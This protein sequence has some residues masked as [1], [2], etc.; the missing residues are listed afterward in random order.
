[1]LH[2]GYGK[3][4]G[5]EKN[6][7]TNTQSILIGAALVVVSL[8]VGYYLGQ[9]SA[10]SSFKTAVREVTGEQETNT[11]METATSSAVAVDTADLTPEQRA[12]FESYGIDPD[13]IS[14]AMVA[15]AEAKLGAA[16][17]EAIARGAEVSMSERASLVA[18]YRP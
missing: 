9:L 17:L 14:P 12:R 16:R 15:C 1:M 18:C 6:M 4:M 2:V 10:D 13:R 7:T 11:N 8:A 3:F 5:T